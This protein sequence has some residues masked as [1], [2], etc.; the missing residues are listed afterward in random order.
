M[1]VFYW[2]TRRTE[3]K[4]GLVAEFCPLCRDISAFRI[5]RVGLAS[6]VY[7]I[8]FGQGRL[9][10]HVIECTA[11][12]LR[13]TADP[14]KYALF[15][16]ESKVAPIPLG[17]LERLTYP[18]VRQVY[19]PRLA[20]ETQ[21]RR[22][23][24][25]LT[26]EQR[27]QLLLEPFR[28]LN[29]RVEARYSTSL[30]FDRY[31]SLGCVGTLLF[32]F[33]LLSVAGT[34]LEPRATYLIVASLVFFGLGVAYTLGQLACAA[35]RFLHTEVVRALARSLDPLEPTPDELQGC[36]AKCKAASMKIGQKLKLP[37]LWAELERHA[38]GLVVADTAA[39][40]QPSDLRLGDY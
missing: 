33:L 24:S 34:L 27:A 25:V 20:L 7:A 21:I 8:P 15:A 30:K 35:G 10:G 36:L 9:A 28:L 37:V 23:A 11:C 4:Q 32:T 6:H 31:S 26:P 2:G 18:T 5:L 13:L 17:E 22:T 38:A 29:P 3:K 19:A 40:R 12:G 39:T 16:V 14:L 1:F